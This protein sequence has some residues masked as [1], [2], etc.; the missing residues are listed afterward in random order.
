M[1]IS[2]AVWLRGVG[3]IGD[4]NSL[5][6]KNFDKLADKVKVGGFGLA[7]TRKSQAEISV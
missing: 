1:P 6:R 7:F 2:E 5:L 4:R 3:N